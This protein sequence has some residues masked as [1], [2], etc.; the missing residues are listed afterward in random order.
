[1]SPR[2]LP[3]L[4]SILLV[5]SG[6][7]VW[8]ARSVSGSAHSVDPDAIEFRTYNLSRSGAG[9]L[10]KGSVQ[11][12]RSDRRGGHLAEIRCRASRRAWAALLRT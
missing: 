2:S 9:L 12:C 5:L 1:M 4:L 3:V 11:A 10:A 6:V 8:Q 7:C